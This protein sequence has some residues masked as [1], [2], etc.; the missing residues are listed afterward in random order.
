MSIVSRRDQIRMDDDEVRD[1]LDQSRTVI[2]NSIG[3]DGVPHPIPMWYAIQE[4]GEIVMATYTKSQKIRNLQRDPRVSLLVE[5]GTDYSELR[6]VLIYGTVDL[7]HDTEGV[8]DILTAVFSRQ[9]DP[10]TQAAR[11]GLRQRAKKRTGI[12][13]RPAKVVSWDHRKLGAVY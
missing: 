7:V 6:G 9:G 5:D 13:V 4:G 2:I 3:R 12:R 1:F 8:I 11:A 10:L